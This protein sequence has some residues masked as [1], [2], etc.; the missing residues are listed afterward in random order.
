MS[1]WCHVMSNRL[2]LA[3]SCS[4]R[5]GVAQKLHQPP[6]RPAAERVF[7]G[8]PPYFVHPEIRDWSCVRLSSSMRHR[9]IINGRFGCVYSDK[10]MHRVGR[11]TEKC[12]LNLGSRLSNFCPKTQCPLIRETLPASLLCHSPLPYPVFVS[13]VKDTPIALLIVYITLHMAR[14]GFD[15]SCYLCLWGVTNV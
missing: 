6:C 9:V 5:K 1:Q 13:V 15:S 10:V 2:V 8:R 11:L 4:P 7:R 3:H 12:E 14:S